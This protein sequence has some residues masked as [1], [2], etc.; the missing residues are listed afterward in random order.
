MILCKYIL[1]IF[2]IYS[3]YIYIYTHENQRWSAES[4]VSNLSSGHRNSK[5]ISKHLQICGPSTATLTSIVSNCHLFKFPYPTLLHYGV[6]SWSLQPDAKQPK[7]GG[8]KLKILVRK[9]RAHLFPTRFAIFK[10]AFKLF[11]DPDHWWK[12]WNMSSQL[13]MNGTSQKGDA[14]NMIRRSCSFPLGFAMNVHLSHH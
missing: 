8:W 9:I 6:P 14:T 7:N 1:Y 4:V 12:G 10:W 11:N 3:I 2:Y 5:L 13:L